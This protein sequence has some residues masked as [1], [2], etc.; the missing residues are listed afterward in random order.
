[1]EKLHRLGLWRTLQE[2]EEPCSRGRHRNGV[3][4]IEAFLKHLTEVEGERMDLFY[5]HQILSTE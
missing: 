4:E 2:C 3:G 1:M 5:L